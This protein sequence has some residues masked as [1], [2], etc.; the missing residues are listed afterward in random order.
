MGMGA[1]LAID[2]FFDDIEQAVIRVAPTPASLLG[3][4]VW[5]AGILAAFITNDAVCVLGAP[6]VL[7]LIERHELPPLPY[8]LALA[9][10]A[11]SGSVATLVGNP[12]N[13]LCAI[14]GHLSYRDHLLLVGPI[15][16]LGLM[17]N[18][19]LLWLF[20]RRKLTARP[21]VPENGRPAV[22][23]QTGVTLAVIFATAVAFTAGADLAWAATA[24]FALLM[25]VHRRD[26]RQLWPRI[27]WALLVFFS[28]LFIV[29][30]TLFQSGA[31]AWLFARFP[32]LDPGAPA[33]A[34]AWLRLAAIFLVGSN[35]VSNVPFIL[36]VREQMATLPDPRLGWELLAMASTFA[37][38]LTLL[39]SVANIIVAESAR[40]HGG[41]GF[42]EY[43]KVGFPLA[44]L[45]TLVGVGWML[46]VS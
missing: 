29:V 10:G 46:L 40:D 15:A 44:I 35:I 34:G 18:H 8:L 16:L 12:Q 42:V 27:D 3:A 33:G 4:V 26:T 41:I 32:L 36:V 11:N 37:G 13:M 45:S 31:P 2:G 30:E 1:F 28:G 9:T 17:L 24:G 6:L 5:G 39:G 21:L 20:F 38:N 25:L 43:L 7:R 19:G 22:R 14:L 23:P